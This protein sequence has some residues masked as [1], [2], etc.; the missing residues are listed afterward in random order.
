MKK[1]ALAHL[2]TRLVEPNWMLQ[3]EEEIQKQ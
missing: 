2:E 3:K 1:I